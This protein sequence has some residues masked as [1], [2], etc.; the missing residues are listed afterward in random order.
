VTSTLLA[1]ARRTV[2]GV[3]EREIQAFKSG[4]GPK[5]THL[6]HAVRAAVGGYHAVVDGGSL[7]D[8]MQRVDIVP[9]PLRGYAYEGV[10]MGLTGLDLVTPGPS[11]LRAFLAGPGN[12]HIY[13]SHIGVGEALARLKRRPEP[14][15][16]R[17]EDPVLRW[18][19]LDGY[20]F[21]QGFF[22]RPRFVDHQQVP[23]FLSP[24]GKRIFDQGVGRS[25]WF[26]AGADI[27]RISADI[28]AFAPRRHADLWVGVGVACSYVGGLPRSDIID[29][30]NACGRHLPSVATGVA[31]AARGR[32]RAANVISGTDL[33]C[34]VLCGVNSDQ[35]STLVQ[36]TF[37][38]LPVR[39]PRPGYELLLAH[40]RTTFSASIPAPA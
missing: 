4:A 6:E 12:G 40:L 32:H 26:T 13:M 3:P 22:A 9:E 1:R 39:S 5:W 14:Y 18:L 33:A 15:L 10:A 2:M 11:R 24:F 34:D 37:D 27:N 23:G 36:N 16:A 7:G 21:H 38:I 25:I 20:G 19:V 28:A 31:F 30:R 29:L 17:L 35:A 8:I